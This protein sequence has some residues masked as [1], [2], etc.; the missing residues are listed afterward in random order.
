MGYNLKNIE[1]SAQKNLIP[2]PTVDYLLNYFKKNELLIKNKNYVTFVDFRKPSSED[3]M[4][5]INTETGQSEKYLVAHGRNSGDVYAEKF[6]NKID[7]KMSS[8]GLFIVGEK[9]QGENGTS[10]HLIGLNETNSNAADRGIVIHYADYVSKNWANEQGRIGR[11]WG[12]FAL[13][14]ND[15]LNQILQKIKGGSLMIAFK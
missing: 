7:S 10:L 15:F 1:L 8:L 14:K 9:Y 13:N 3:R 6:S 12:C 4:I 11:S 5:L 2:K